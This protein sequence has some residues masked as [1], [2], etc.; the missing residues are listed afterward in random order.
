MRKIIVILLFVAFPV[1]SF[2]Q[3][4]G[5]GTTVPSE[6]LEIKNPLRTTV[7]ISS[8]SFD[9]TTELLFSNRNGIN[10]GTDFSVKSVR[11]QGLFFSSLSDLPA[12]TNSNSLVIRSNGN[13]GIGT[14]PA[15]K[16]HVTGQ[17]RFNGLTQIDGLNLLELGAG[18]AGKEINAGKIGYNAFGQN[19]L[20]FV[21]AG[22]NATNRAVYF[23]A[24]GGTT[25][26]GP[27]NIGGPL[28]VNGNPGAVGQVLTS[29]GTTEP[30]WQNSSFTN[31]TRFGVRFSLN[32]N[33]LAPMPVAETEYNLNTAD[34]AIGT[35][36]I[37]INKSG[38]YKLNGVLTGIVTYT[39]TVE[40]TFIPQAETYI[41]F[42]GTSSSTLRLAYHENFVREAFVTSPA[43]HYRNNFSFDVYLPAGTTIAVFNDLFYLSPPATSI[44]NCTVMLYANLI[45]E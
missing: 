7:K 31:S 35:N 17:S 38:L 14:L 9:D 5:I 13:I 22:T 41:Q 45:S 26:N 21:G 36:T 2:S 29:N 39:G 37:T 1:I 44:T 10:A 43:Y 30:V 23:F 27:L 3:N 20:T 33:G 19:A 16:F 4:V 12:N 8:A 24:E 42:G 15:F 11:E 32:T 40:P 28:R 18:V 25:M 34:I 6:K